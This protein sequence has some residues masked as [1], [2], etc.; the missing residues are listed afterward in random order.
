M[1]TLVTLQSSCVLKPG[2]LLRK[3]SHRLEASVTV[4]VEAGLPPRAPYASVTSDLSP[5]GRVP[6]V[7]L[8]S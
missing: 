1:Q 5:T 4:R 6:S 3:E 8:T 2:D 7:P